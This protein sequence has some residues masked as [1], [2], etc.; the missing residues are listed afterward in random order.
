MNARVSMKIFSQTC[1]YLIFRG[2]FLMK[3]IWR[4]QGVACQNSY[5]TTIEDIFSCDTRGG[6][7][8]VKNPI[9]F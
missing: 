7:C 4:V 9:I 8:G 3:T 6:M 1:M 5:K 2:D